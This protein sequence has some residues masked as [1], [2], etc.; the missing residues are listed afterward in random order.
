MLVRRDVF[1][2]RIFFGFCNVI[3]FLDRLVVFRLLSPFFFTVSGLFLYRFNHKSYRL[4]D[5]R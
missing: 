4:F 1:F 5:A 3:R 2:V